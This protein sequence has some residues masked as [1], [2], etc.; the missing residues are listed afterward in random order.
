MG[1]HE[2]GVL[3]GLS[4]MISAWR[5]VVDALH[6]GEEERSEVSAS[7][8]GAGPSCC[9]ESSHAECETDAIGNAEGATVNVQQLFSCGSQ[10]GTAPGG[11]CWDKMCLSPLT[12]LLVPMYAKCEN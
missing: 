4:N 10:Y 2:D 5:H 11:G 3:Y 8:I 9:P 7:L 1:N 12:P 6:Q